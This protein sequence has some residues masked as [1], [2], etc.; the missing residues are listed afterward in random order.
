MD[1]VR[2][3]AGLLGGAILMLTSAA[4]WK[5]GWSSLSEQL[6][7]AHVPVELVQGIWVGWQFGGAAMLAFGLI[8]VMTFASWRQGR[9]VSLAP[10]QVIAGAYLLFGVWALVV[11]AYDPFFLMFIVPALLIGFASFDMSTKP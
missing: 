8:V 7:V 6:A 11:T 10:A 5:L 2:D 3:V 4:H 9:P 1:R